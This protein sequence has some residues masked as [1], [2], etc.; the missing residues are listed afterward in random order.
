MYECKVQS[1]PLSSHGRLHSTW[2]RCGGYVVEDVNFRHLAEQVRQR[3]HRRAVARLWAERLEPKLL[4]TLSYIYIYISI[5]IYVY[6]CVYIYLYR[7]I[8]RYR[9]QWTASKKIN[10]VCETTKSDKWVAIFSLVRVTQPGCLRIQNTHVIRMECFIC[11]CF[12]TYL[13]PLFSIFL[14]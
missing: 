5:H 3:A 13:K 14:S 6:I 4:R 12:Q 2:S 7:Y 8:E 11:F 1:V 10:L 9:G